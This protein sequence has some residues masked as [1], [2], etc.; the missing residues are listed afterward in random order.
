MSISNKNVGGNIARLRMARNMTQ[1]Q[2]ASA[3]GVS[4]Q[5]VSKWEN[6]AALPDLETLLN[7]SRLFG[8]TMEQ[9]LSNS[10]N[11]TENEENSDYFD[12]G[13][14]WEGIKDA[15]DHTVETAKS[16]GNILYNK[17]SK[18]IENAAELIKEGTQC[19][20]EDEEDDGAE[21][22]CVNE[23]ESE[24][25]V[26]EDKSE[27][28]PAEENEAAEAPVKRFSPDALL[29]LAPFMSREK[30]SELVL[31]YDGDIPTP[32]LVQLAPFL[33]QDA[34]TSLVNKAGE[35]SMSLD[36]I[37]NFAPFLRQDMLFKLIMN[38]ADKLDF[39]TLK[40]LAPFLKKGM[41][42]L[43][44]DVMCGIRKT[45]NLDFISDFA[46]K[47]R[48]SIEIM[49][50]KIAGG[51]NAIDPT[52]RAD[53]SKKDVDEAK[54]A[55]DEKTAETDEA[56][57]EEAAPSEIDRL[58]RG[59]L[60]TR[61]WSWIRQNLSH[62]NSGALLEEIVLT[63]SSELE[64]DDARDMLLNAAPYMDAKTFKS[65]TIKLCDGGYWARICDLSSLTDAESAGDILV[66]A[67]DGGK[68]ALDAVRLYAPKAPRE[69]WN[70][71][72]QKAINEGEW[73]LVNALTENMSAN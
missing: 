52:K 3:L 51:L 15:A 41:V 18:A 30:V 40:K 54:K 24:N 19:A 44:V 10:Q 55:D 48:K 42:D 25:D 49:F 59:A 57:K 67:A 23:D 69:V 6:G 73:E 71:V 63:A 4:H 38:N 66:M 29:Q 26:N 50:N 17:V 8:V 36:V 16:I 32:Q 31:N 46:G 21:E 33:T 62:I 39:A 13:I 53:E 12:P 5:A 11:E 68:K 65:G 2:L 56:P 20:Q 47:T 60:D 27:G 61:S 28:A 58:C 43:L 22:S 9:L 37:V 1:Q 70:A 45:V 72:S 34:L 35:D 14:M 64:A 7:L